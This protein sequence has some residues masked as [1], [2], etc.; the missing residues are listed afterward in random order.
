M[1]GLKLHTFSSQSWPS[2][3]LWTCD[4]DGFSP[5]AVLQVASA[6]TGVPFDRVRE[7]TLG[8]FSG[9]VFEKHQPRGITPWILPLGVYH[10]QRRRHGNQCC[11]KCLDESPHFRR[12]WRLAFSTV[13]VRHHVALI[14]RCPDCSAPIAFHRGDI[15]DRASF[16]ASPLTSCHVCGFDF[17]AFR[18]RRIAA[19]ARI[20]TFQKLLENVVSTGGVQVGA[21]PVFGHL[22][23][24]GLRILMRLCASAKHGQTIQAEI[25]KR[26]G[27][28]RVVPDW[29]NANLA[30]ENLSIDDRRALLTFSSVLLEDWPHGFV[31]VV[32]RLKIRASDISGHD[33]S[34]PY[35]VESVVGEYLTGYKHVPSIEEISSVISFL[36]GKGETP[37]RELVG[38]Y[39][40]VEW[41]RKR[42]LLY[43]LD[44]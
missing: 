5:E 15:G 6:R 11:A 27:I 3:S 28:A 10:R 41:F 17:R 1:N 13:C 30:L 12:M 39:V 24:S 22:F 20:M 16:D 9:L 33:R 26:A 32:K 38:R 21:V 23:F 36:R 25:A 14:D 34:V 18:A 37:T 2:L 29:V 35:W 43:L 44:A 31:E 4:V 8:A 19:N 42:S 40:G 7:T